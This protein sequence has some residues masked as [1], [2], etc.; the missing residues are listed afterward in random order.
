MGSIR[1]W[2]ALF[3]VLGIGLFDWAVTK[4][5]HY[6]VWRY[7]F[8]PANEE[9]FMMELDYNPPASFVRNCMPEHKPERSNSLNFSEAM[10]EDHPDEEQVAAELLRKKT[11]PSKQLE[12]T[13]FDSKPG[14]GA[15]QPLLDQ[16]SP[17]GAQN[18]ASYQP[19][20]SPAPQ[21]YPGSNGYSAATQGGRAAPFNPY[22]Q[23][24]GQQYGQPVAQAPQGN[25]YP[26]QYQ[27][28]RSYDFQ[29]NPRT[30][31]R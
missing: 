7:H 18:Q 9:E 26:P 1:F 11:E 4:L 8:P 17:Y 14:Q 16:P 24:V 27:Q 30:I 2:T 22:N 5:N 20:Y 21:V 15:S 29:P 3:L 12:M 6:T 23:P 31:Y 13:G 25:Y 28:P 19:Q 10:V